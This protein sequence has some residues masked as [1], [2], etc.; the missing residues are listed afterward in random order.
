MQARRAVELVVSTAAAL[1]AAGVVA[2][3]LL[4]S[5]SRSVQAQSASPL[6]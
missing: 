2:C 3:L 1:V 6:L 4:A 5:C